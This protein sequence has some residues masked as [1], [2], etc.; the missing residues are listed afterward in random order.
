MQE[1]LIVYYRALVAFLIMSATGSLALML[2]VISFGLLMDFNRRFLVAYSSRLILKLIGV[3]LILP[4]KSAYPKRQVFYTFNHN[5]Y[6]DVLII[7]ALGLTNNRFILSVKTYKFVPM[8]ISA[9]AIG[10]LYIP[11]KKDME[12]R[13]KFFKNTE[14][15]IIKEGCSVFASSEGVHEFVH[16]VAPFNKGIYH[17]AINC[18]LPVQPVYFHIPRAVNS[19]E[20]AVF[21]S[22]TV[23]VELLKMI[24]TRDW[25]VENLVEHVESVREVFLQKFSEAHGESVAENSF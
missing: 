23:R 11:L 7:T 1:K 22:G 6:L 19:L 15:K 12:Q 21:K 13:M 5:S 18:S 24:E 8:T 17:M 2:R 4:P 3:T 16:G 9:L 25:S 20:G 14:L 10:T